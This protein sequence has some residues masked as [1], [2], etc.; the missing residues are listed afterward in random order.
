MGVAPCFREGS[1]IH[2][3]P[4][5]EER[6][7]D[8]RELQLAA[9]LVTGDLGIH[10]GQGQTAGLPHQAGQV[11]LSQRLGA[12]AGFGPVHPRFVADGQAL[13]ALNV[14]VVRGPAGHAL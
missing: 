7:V 2:L 3:R 11:G 13:A 1:L 6:G 4:L 8:G 10:A 12:G 9:P 14:D 5:G